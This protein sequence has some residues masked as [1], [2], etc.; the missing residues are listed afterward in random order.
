MN[1][2]MEGWDD[3]SGADQSDITYRSVFASGGYSGAYPP[4]IT[5]R[6]GFGKAITCQQPGVSGAYEMVSIPWTPVGRCFIGFAW[7]Y[8]GI[9]GAADDV[10]RLKSGTYN[11]FVLRKVSL[12]AFSISWTTTGSGTLTQTIAPWRN[13]NSYC[14]FCV[15][16]VA[17]TI[18]V[19][20]DGVSVFTTGTNVLIPG[21]IDSLVLC[22]TSH[23]GPVTG[24]VVD[25]LYV[26][27]ATGSYNNT[28]WG[29]TR[30]I[31]IAPNS[32]G[33]I[34]TMIPSRAGA[35]YNL[36]NEVPPDED[37]TY[38]AATAVGQE[39]T[40]NVPNL[41][42]TNNVGTLHAL[43]V[44]AY[45]RTEFGGLVKIKGVVRKAGVDYLGPENSVPAVWTGL[46]SLFETN[47][48]T[49]APWTVADIGVTQFG[50]RRTV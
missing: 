24:A 28:F 19:H 39:D 38:V 32:D 21:Y 4:F 6:G 35:H 10:I 26:N 1:I 37:A 11:V 30:I 22:A 2:F 27:D 14:E 18:E 23:A 47:P 5:G 17:S 41:G 31:S 33:D 20:V 7:D 15:D 50:E 12:T 9:S 13:F 43:Q 29:D 49:G 42:T 3:F 25:D 45:C 48:A 44:M 34:Q 40:Y 46:P 36:V 8:T 16:P